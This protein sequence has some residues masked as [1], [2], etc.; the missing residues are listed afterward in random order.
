[1]DCP[2]TGPRLV[3][4][5][6]VDRVDVRDWPE[7]LDDLI[8]RARFGNGE[9]WWTSAEAVLRTESEKTIRELAVIGLVE[10][11]TQVHKIERDVEGPCAGTTLRRGL[12]R[13]SGFND[14][15]IAKAE[16]ETIG[17]HESDD[18]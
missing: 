10:L 13:A 12:L 6:E 15:A 8:M 7:H 14:D 4:K 18:E 9:D 16:A 1:M 5:T 17:R 2:A 11:V 3:T